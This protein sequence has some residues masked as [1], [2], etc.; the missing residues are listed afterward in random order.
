M[1]SFVL[2]RNLHWV[3]LTQGETVIWINNGLIYWRIHAS[4]SFEKI[5]IYHRKI[6]FLLI[7]YII[8]R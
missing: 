8:I 5:H 3:L 7:A 6:S 2:W 1:K 4:S